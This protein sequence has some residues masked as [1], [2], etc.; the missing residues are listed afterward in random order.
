MDP[1]K[2]LSEAELL[3]A[4]AAPGTA[5]VGAQR[6]KRAGAEAAVVARAVPVA[7]R[8]AVAP[9]DLVDLRALQ[10]IEHVVRDAGIVQGHDVRGLQRQDGV[11][12]LDFVN[13]LVRGSA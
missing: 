10:I 3:M 11:G 2:T 7:L 5:S 13:D 4:L 6:R 12:A 1:V 9:A 8:I